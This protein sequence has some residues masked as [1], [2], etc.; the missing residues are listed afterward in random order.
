MRRALALLFFLIVLLPSVSA[1]G[2]SPAILTLDYKTSGEYPLTFHA[3][4][5][6]HM[7][8][9][10]KGDLASYAEIID[11]YPH[12]GPRDFQVIIRLPKDIDPPG[13]RTLL[14]GVL[15]QPP[16]GAM[17]GARAAYQAPVFIYVPYPGVYLDVTLTAPSV[18]ENE[19]VPFRLD[20]INHGRDPAVGVT[21]SL[22]IIDGATNATLL[23]LDS[24]TAGIK[25]Q[26]EN[27]FVWDWTT[28]GRTPGPYLARSVVSY[29][30]KDIERIEPFRI[31]TQQLRILNFTRSARPGLIA[32][33]TVTVKSEWNSPFAGVYAD[34]SINDTKIRTPALD[35][36]PWETQTLTGYWDLNGASPGDYKADIKVPYGNTYAFATGTVTV[37]TDAPESASWIAGMGIRLAIAGLLAVAA[38]LFLALGRRREKK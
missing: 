33:F 7:D 14:V 13:K 32:P 3:L 24:Q 23:S 22:S 27:V 12:G 15:E 31:G 19:T 34:I 2:L 11:P 38:L 26:G 8:T 37:S 4:G 25:G 20:V 9:Y 5:A 35:L 30:G 17:V 1:V 16:N 6:E 28:V 10:V 36:A 18:N 21:A 29:G